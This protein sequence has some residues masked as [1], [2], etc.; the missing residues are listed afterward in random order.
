M[1]SMKKAFAFV[2]TGDSPKEPLIIDSKKAG[3]APR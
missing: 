1:E 2:G 3:I